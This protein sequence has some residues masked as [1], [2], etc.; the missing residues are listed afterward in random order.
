MNILKK[1]DP[2]K[3]EFKSEFG[4]RLRAAREKANLQGNEFAEKIGMGE[5]NYNPFDKGKKIP[6][7]RYLVDMANELNVSPNYLLG[8]E[9]E[10]SLADVAKS[11]MVLYFYEGV[12]MK[13]APTWD[14]ESGMKKNEIEIKITKGDLRRFMNRFL[15]LPTDRVIEQGDLSALRRTL[16]E[17]DT[18]A[19]YSSMDEQT[20]KNIVNRLSRS[21]GGD[22]E[23]ATKELEK[24]IYGGFDHGEPQ[25]EDEQ[26]GGEVL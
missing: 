11:L 6:G 9:E 20:W 23:K 21:Y 7:T 18:K 24:F 8:Y 12:E 26:E 10:I 14:F 1:V 3:P 5:T 22:T 15:K 17:L 2:S 19:A 25:T 4:A 13:L 16:D